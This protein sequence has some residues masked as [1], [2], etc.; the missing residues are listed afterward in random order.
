[1]GLYS[2]WAIGVTSEGYVDQGINN[3][4]SDPDSET[5]YRLG[6]RVGISNMLMIALNLW[7]D[8]SR[9]T[10]LIADQQSNSLADIDDP[11]HSE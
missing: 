3:Q 9:S 2:N 11:P 5:Y 7:V 10:D 4:I 1:M 6:S 8:S